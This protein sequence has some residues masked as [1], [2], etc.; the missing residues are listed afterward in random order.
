M[1]PNNNYSQS[2]QTNSF[3]NNSNLAQM[4]QNA[5]FNTS[6]AI[7]SINNFSD[8]KSFLNP[9]NYG[10][11]QFYSTQMNVL[12]MLKQHSKMISSTL[13]GA[14]TTGL[15]FFMIN[16]RRKY[17]TD[18]SF[19]LRTSLE[20]IMGFSSLLYQDKVGHT[21]DQQKEFLKYIMDGAKG[22]LAEVSKVELHNIF[23]PTA[24]MAFNLRI[25]LQDIIG[26]A[27]LINT[28]QRNLTTQQK[29]LLSGIL[30]GSNDILKLIPV[31]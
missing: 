4:S 3:M 5:F 27:T 29:D 15:L 23:V 9:I 12:A 1:N 7:N 28:D 8:I 24:E 21:P 17:L 10:L 26:F 30:T 19:K 13:A 2:N 31:K 20:T 16:R 25:G 11:N 6:N 22:I 14:A 18:L